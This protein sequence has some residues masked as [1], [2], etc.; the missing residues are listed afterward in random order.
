M[1]STISPGGKTIYPIPGVPQY[2][3]QDMI[4]NPFIE[5]SDI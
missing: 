3:N 2:I 5:K 4:S 1:L